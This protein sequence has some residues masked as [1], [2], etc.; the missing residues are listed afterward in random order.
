M[1]IERASRLTKVT[2]RVAV[3]VWTLYIHNN[4]IVLDQAMLCVLTHRQSLNDARLFIKSKTEWIEHQRIQLLV[5][6][7]Y[8]QVLYARGN[9]EI[10]LVIVMI[11]NKVWGCHNIIS[12]SRVKYKK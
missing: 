5:L 6:N 9:T 1:V 2:E 4:S 11:I 3:C 12:L 7:K 10:L 8:A